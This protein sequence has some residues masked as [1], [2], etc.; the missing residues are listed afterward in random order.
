[1]S[2]DKDAKWVGFRGG[3][4]GGGRKEPAGDSCEN[5]RKKVSFV[6]N[7]AMGGCCTRV[8]FKVNTMQAITSLCT[9][10]RGSYMSLLGKHNI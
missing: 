2:V 10:L 4:G 1:M 5:K 7:G 9:E 6:Q 8:D 3:G